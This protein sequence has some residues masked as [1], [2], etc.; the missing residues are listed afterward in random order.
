MTLEE[1]IHEVSNE[2]TDELKLQL[3]EKNIIIENTEINNKREKVLEG[4]VSYFFWF[5]FGSFSYSR[6]FQTEFIRR[7]S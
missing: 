1:L 3:E 4:K 5:T 2:E 7:C 6:E